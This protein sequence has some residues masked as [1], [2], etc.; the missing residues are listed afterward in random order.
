[1]Y[2]CT[3][4]I[5]IETTKPKIL[6]IID[7]L[8]EMLKGTKGSKTFFSAIINP[9]R[10]TIDI[11]RYMLKRYRLDSSRKAKAMKL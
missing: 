2:V 11:I 7:G 4:I 10:A 9:I 6:V 1:M 3:A 5:I 8:L